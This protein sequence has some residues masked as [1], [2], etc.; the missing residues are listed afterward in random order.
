MSITVQ[1]QRAPVQVV[2]QGQRLSN[3]CHKDL[4]VDSANV[5]Q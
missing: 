5:S 1:A 2:V 4:T 3:V